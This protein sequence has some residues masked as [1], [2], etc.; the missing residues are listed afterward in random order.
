MIQTANELNQI[1]EDDL[2]AHV[3]AVLLTLRDENA[4]A[5]LAVAPFITAHVLLQLHNLVAGARKLDIQASAGWSKQATL[6]LVVGTFTGVKLARSDAEYIGNAQDYFLRDY[7][8]HLSKAEKSEARATR[9]AALAGRMVRFGDAGE[10]RAEQLKLQLYKCKFG[11]V[12]RHVLASHTPIHKQ[13]VPVRRAI[14]DASKENLQLKQ[15]INELKEAHAIQR[16]MNYNLQQLCAAV[17]QERAQ[18]KRAEVDAAEVA[19]RAEEA[20]AQTASKAAAE[21]HACKRQVREA[22]KNLE[23]ARA[24][25]L[26]LGSQITVAN[27]EQWKAMERE[28]KAREESEQALAQ[29]AQAQ[30]M[31][32]TRV[33]SKLQALHKR[34]RD[35]ER[36]REWAEGRA[37]KL[38]RKVS[39]AQI[40][41]AKAMEREKIVREDARV[42]LQTMLP[43]RRQ[44]L[45]HRCLNRCEQRSYRDKRLKR[46]VMC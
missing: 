46:R 39:A 8:K 11:G 6:A 12:P 1:S 31:A 32:E 38:G 41:Q 15:Q 5:V 43:K 21:V 44:K 37:L 9:R 19:S 14:Y 36:E 22:E 2:R 18:R 45:L 40:E 20:Q 26:C 10:S 17:E 28:R 3:D 7:M 13:A 33:K 27:V 25:V 30:T 42:K 24:R 16:D 23:Q 29:A 34:V 4:P 35:A